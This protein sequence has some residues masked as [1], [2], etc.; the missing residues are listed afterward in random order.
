MRY[1]ECISSCPRT[2]SNVYAVSASSCDAGRCYPGCHCTP[3]TFLSTTHDDDDE[4]LVHDLSNLY[5]APSLTCVPVDECPCRYQGRA[6][7]P[8][9]VV[10]VNCNTWYELKPNSITLAG[11]ELVRSWFGGEIWPI[12]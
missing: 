7:P 4:H 1:S 2:C 3:G 9:S 6:Y 11:S 8:G 5:I 12:I 10:E